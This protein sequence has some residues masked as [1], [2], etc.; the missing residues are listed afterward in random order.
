MRGDVL[1]RLRHVA[2]EDADGRERPAGERQHHRRHEKTGDALH[3]YLRPAKPD[4]TD[5]VTETSETS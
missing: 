4:A 3:R 2:I 5:C 1:L